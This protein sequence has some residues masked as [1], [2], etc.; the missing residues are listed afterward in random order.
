MTRAEPPFTIGIEE[1]YL[2]VD[3]QSRDVVS[4]P[5]PEIFAECESRVGNGLIEH[6]LLR[7]QIEAD[8]RICRTVSEAR[9]ELLRLR[10]LT[11]RVAARHGLAPIAASTHPFATWHLQ[12]YT[13][14]S[15]Y[16]LLAEGMQGLA[17]RLLICGMHVHVGI[18][19]DE[20]R[21]ELMN[22]FAPFLPLLL[23][24]STSSPFWQ[25]ENTGLKSYRLTVFDTY[26]R[27]GLPER[28]TDHAEYRELVDLL[29]ATGVIPD[30]S[31]IWWDTRISVRYPTLETRIMDMCSRVDD[32]AAIAALVQ[33]L[34]HYLYRTRRERRSRPPLRRFLIAQ[35]RWR[36][37]R[38]GLDEGLVDFGRRR[39]M[40]VADWLAEIVE[41]VAPDADALGCTAELRHA[42]DIPQRG[43]SAH[44]QVECFDRALRQGA[45]T[46][47]AL[48]GVV[49]LLI[50]ETVQGKTPLQRPAGLGESGAFP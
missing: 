45:S 37:M 50:A 11:A 6:E 23:A 19:D 1:E 43:T 7:S 48:I 2:L 39:I 30:G 17:R 46:R 34:L 13:P 35:N 32:A 15:R 42:L 26:P 29:T 36:A 20:L 40:P 9:D 41:A 27:T 10:R 3:R 33:S 5:P 18:D 8:T 22:R 4:N 21:V 47:K 49:D 28:F 44:R 25:G 24:L 12:R 38:Y 16:K 31:F 14:K